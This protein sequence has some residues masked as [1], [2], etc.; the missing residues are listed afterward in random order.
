MNK[1]NQYSCAKHDDG[2]YVFIKPEFLDINDEYKNSDP[3]KVFLNKDSS[4]QKRRFN[5]TIRLLKKYLN[6]NKCKVLDVACGEGHI[7]NK[8]KCEFPNW[9][10][11]GL[12]Y[13]LSAIMFANRSYSNINFIVADAYN[14]P[15]SKKFFDVI[16]LNNIWEHV[17][18]PLHLLKEVS[19]IIKD[20][21]YVVISTP[22]RYRFRNLIRIFLGK[23]IIFNS[24]HHV[25]EYSVGQV[26]EQ[27]FYGGYQITD[28]MSTYSSEKNILL[29]LVKILIYYFLKII[30]SHH[31]LESTVFYL[32]KKT[33]NK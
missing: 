2:F 24:K 1:N 5:L 12:D 31:N 29:R 16:I 6:N 23:P 10:V 11:Y 4:F 19:K 21:G 14:P 33:Y 26:K 22:S 15:F 17:A 7:T 30:K 32:A 3:Y 9:E 8:I 13:S 18:D 25:T 27:L 20:N 28:V